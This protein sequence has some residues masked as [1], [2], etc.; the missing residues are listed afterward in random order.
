MIRKFAKVAA[1]RAVSAILF[2]ATVLAATAVW[3]QQ[4]TQQFQTPQ[5]QTQQPQSQQPPAD[6][7]GSQE[8]SPEETESARKPKP[9]EYNNWEF[10][11]GGGV[12]LDSGTTRTYARSGSGVADVGF[13]HNTSKYFGFRVDA[14]WA[15]LPLRNSALELAQAPG[16]SSY[17]L[18]L[19]FDPIITLPVNNEWR[20]YVVF[21]PN[22]IHRG[23]K[24]DSSGVLAGS[25]CNGFW[26]WWGVCFAGSLPVDNKVL[27]ASQNEFGYNAGVG[28]ARKI[29]PKIEVYG[30][31][32]F[33][34]GTHGGITTDYRPI[35][36]GV[37][38]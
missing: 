7:S 21:G 14:Q 32:R 27:S 13:A 31:F 9:H 15:D 4:T 8:A 26:T 22:Y 12:G 1:C 24:L 35:T 23:G 25:A 5:P 28:V 34:H 19:M 36:I 11:V 38:W 33:V 17:A 29:R 37:R 18:T 10:N 6:Q 2:S 30:E 20:A 16:A 3:A